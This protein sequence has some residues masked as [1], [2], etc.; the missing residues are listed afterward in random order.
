LAYALYARLEPVWLLL[1]WIGLVPWLVTVDRARSWPRVLA[2]GLLMSVCFTLA[3]FGWFAD[4]ICTYTG[5]PVAGALV[6]LGLAGPLVQPQFVVLALVRRFVRA[7]AGWLATALAGACLYVGTEWALPKLF[8][9][10]LGH[11]LYASR[12]MRQAADLAGAPGLSL[13]LLVANAAAAEVWHAL[14]GGPGREPSAT[15][16]LAIRLRA[17][18]A[19]LLAIV[20]LAAALF[21]Y[22]ALRLRQLADV[23]GGAPVTAGIVQGNIGHYDEWRARI[24]AYATVRMVLDTYFRMSDDVRRRAPV[25]LLVWPETV[26]PTTFAAPK[27]EDGAALDREIV[28]YATRAGVPLVFG[29]YDIE[30]GTEYNAAFFLEPTAAAASGGTG[31]AGDARLV[32][33]YRKAWPFPLT[34]HVPA[35]LDTPRVRAWLPWLGTWQAGNGSKVVPLRLADGRTLHVA[36]LI[37]YDVLDPTLAL[38]ATRAGADLIVTLSNDSWFAAGAG[39]RQHLLGAAFRSLETRRPQLRATNTGISAVITPA[40]DIVERGDLDAQTGM[41]ATIVPR[42][43][44]ISLAVAW[45]D[46]LGPVALVL[47]VLL[48]LSRTGRSFGSARSPRRRAA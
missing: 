1:G 3:V 11:G 20:A 9:D 40:G 31:A 24:G 33:S 32:A 39:P 19:P 37:C 41:V 22:G 18:R 48:L 35:F 45:G 25:D 4:A 46:W 38:A 2:I 26:Y 43:R 21:G 17:A 15:A 42:T 23:D 8:G 29:A 28:D 16:P 12:W 7:R 13:V 14:S 36:P 44:P 30:R 6:V 27:S 47:G 10:T 34:E 5:L